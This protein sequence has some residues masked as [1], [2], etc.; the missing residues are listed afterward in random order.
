MC[1]AE[2]IF[3]LL[4]EV[5]NFL[6]QAS[7]FYTKM[8]NILLS[9]TSQH[10][11]PWKSG[12]NHDISRQKFLHKTRQCYSHVSN[13]KTTQV[14]PHYLQMFFLKI[15]TCTISNNQSHLNK[16]IAIIFC[17]DLFVPVT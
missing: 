14:I 5:F 16:A 17:I 4:H 1:A 12:I 11:F 6:L 3:V 8:F 10:G 13:W 15:A 7:Y 2:E 9:T